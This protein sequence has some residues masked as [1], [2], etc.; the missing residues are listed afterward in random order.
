MEPETQVHDLNRE[1]NLRPSS[2]QT[3]ALTTE[4]LAMVPSNININL[5][6]NQEY[7]ILNDFIPAANFIYLYICFVIYNNI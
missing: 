1:S 7:K 6:N 2:A 4:Q 3:D 5:T